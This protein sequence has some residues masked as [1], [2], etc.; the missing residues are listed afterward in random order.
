MSGSDI[1]VIYTNDVV[2]NANIVAAGIGDRA[3]ALAEQ[4]NLRAKA[5][6][7]K[8]QVDNG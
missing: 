8:R 5:E 6:R 4:K 2:D 1:R 7:L 3:R